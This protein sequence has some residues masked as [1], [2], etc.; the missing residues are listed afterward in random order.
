MSDLYVIFGL[1]AEAY[2]N[3]WLCFMMICKDSLAATQEYAGRAFHNKHLLRASDRAPIVDYK[4]SPCNF[5]IRVVMTGY[6]V[7]RMCVYAYDFGK[8]VSNAAHVFMVDNNNKYT[9]V[10]RRVDT[11]LDLVVNDRYKVTKITTM[12]R[13]SIDIC[14][15]DLVKCHRRVYDII[16]DTNGYSPHCIEAYYYIGSR[17]N[18]VTSRR[19][20]DKSPLNKVF[21]EISK[22]SEFSHWF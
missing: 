5:G 11:S 14:H 17:C 9:D 18:I 20:K 6:I 7:P 12:Y 10:F 22:L 21:V 19:F 4:L 8:M 13:K 2:N 16:T 15:K 1:V 3:C